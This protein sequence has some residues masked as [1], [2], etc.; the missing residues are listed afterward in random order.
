MGDGVE[1]CDGCAAEAVKVMWA[2]NICR[3]YGNYVWRELRGSFV[4]MRQVRLHS[5]RIQESVSVNVTGFFS[6]QL[7][8]IHI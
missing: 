4:S 8:L 7:S 6:T 3:M 5:L 2:V 1:V